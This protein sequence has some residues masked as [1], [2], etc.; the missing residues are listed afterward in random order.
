M[1]KY[2]IERV[3]LC[4]AHQWNTP[5]PCHD[6]GTTHARHYWQVFTSGI[7]GDGSPQLWPCY[8][9]SGALVIYPTYS[10]AWH[11]CQTHA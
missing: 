9:T 10:G 2:K 1:N 5:A 7:D 3:T 6:H 4:D 11:Y 8:R